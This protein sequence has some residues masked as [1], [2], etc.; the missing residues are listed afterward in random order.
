MGVQGNGNM[1]QRSSTHS[2]LR[3]R[4][5]HGLKK[6]SAAA[7]QCGALLHQS[8]NVRDSSSAH[9]SRAECDEH[10]PRKAGSP[11]RRRSPTKKRQPFF[12]ALGLRLT[13]SSYSMEA[14]N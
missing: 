1:D 3:G 4:I 12:R 2:I 11:K 8:Y 14:P 6:E 10:N 9:A 13:T 7:G 5:G